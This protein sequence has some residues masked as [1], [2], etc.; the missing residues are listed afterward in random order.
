MTKGKIGYG[1]TAPNSTTQN[2]NTDPTRE[3]VLVMVNLRK[4]QD[5]T[6]SRVESR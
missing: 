3:L 4:K 5:I 2:G 6:A 1:R